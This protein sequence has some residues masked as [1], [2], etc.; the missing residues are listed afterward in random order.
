M[1]EEILLMGASRSIGLA[2]SATAI[3]SQGGSERSCKVEC[4]AIYQSV[5]AALSVVII[6][7][8]FVVPTLPIIPIQPHMKLYFEVVFA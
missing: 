4:M 2:D 3:R 1:H 5:L 8:F 7:R 6:S